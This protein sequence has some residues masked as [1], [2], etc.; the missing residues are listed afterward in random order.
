MRSICHVER[1]ILTCCPSSPPSAGPRRVA[2]LLLFHATCGD[3]RIATRRRL[4]H[5]FYTLADFYDPKKDRREENQYREGRS[6][7]LLPLSDLLPSVLPFCIHTHSSIRGEREETESTLA[8][9]GVTF[10]FYFFFLS[11][12]CFFLVF[13]FFCRDTVV[14]V[15]DMRLILCG[16]V[17]SRLVSLAARAAQLPPVPGVVY[18][19][20]QYQFLARY[21]EHKE[22]LTPITK[23]FPLRRWGFFKSYKFACDVVQQAAKPGVFQEGEIMPVE[24]LCFFSSSSSASLSG[25]RRRTRLSPEISAQE[26]KVSFSLNAFFPPLLSVGALLFSPS[27]AGPRLRHQTTTSTTTTTT[28]AMR[29]RATFHF[30]SSRVSL[31]L[32]ISLCISLCVCSDEESLTRCCLLFSPLVFWFFIRDACPRDTSPPLPIDQPTSSSVLLLLRVHE[33]VPISSNS[34]GSFL[35]PSCFMGTV[36]AFV[37]PLLSV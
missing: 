1:L 6:E 16:R 10:H 17:G 25:V 32:S 13:V 26:R 36:L 14:H 3:A 15:F 24:D 34:C 35:A 21:Y 28:T 19:A 8:I 30:L 33:G 2:F 7:R 11:I 29:L 9:D 18:D 23:R 27:V 37:R 5:A 20:H 22:S 12:S 4:L 31:C